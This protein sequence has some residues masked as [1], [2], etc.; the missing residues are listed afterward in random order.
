LK[1]PKKRKKMVKNL[2]LL[3]VVVLEVATHCLRKTVLALVVAIHYSRLT[4]FLEVKN[5]DKQRIRG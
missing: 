3:V 1:N 5:R 4:T 2:H